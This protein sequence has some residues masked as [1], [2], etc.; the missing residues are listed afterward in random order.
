MRKWPFIEGLLTGVVL[1]TLSACGAAPATQ[2]APTQTARPTTASVAP[3]RCT[4]ESSLVPTPGP[5]EVA[6]Y[7][8]PSQGEWSLGPSGAPVTII[9]YGDYQ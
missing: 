2:A 4:I 5:T 3:A 9:E 8:A 6:L 7:P 1:F